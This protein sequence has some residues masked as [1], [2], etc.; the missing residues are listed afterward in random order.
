MS[1]RPLSLEQLLVLQVRAPLTESCER[2]I[3]E[4]LNVPENLTGNNHRLNLLTRIADRILQEH[5]SA[6][7]GLEERLF[8]LNKGKAEALAHDHS[9]RERQFAASWFY[10][11]AATA[12]EVL[13]N[14]TQDIS[15][16]ER[17]YEINRLS[18][19]I[20]QG[21]NPPDVRHAAHRY[22]FM[23]K[24]AQTIFERNNDATWAK[25]WYQAEMLSAQ[26]S[27]EKKHQA[28][29]YGKAG[30]AARQLFFITD[31]I[32]WTEKWYEAASAASELHAENFSQS[33]E[34]TSAGE[35]AKV[36]S[37]RTRDLLWA[38]RWYKAEVA[39]AQRSGEKHAARCSGLAG[40]AAASLFEATREL[41][42]AQKALEAYKQY[43]NYATKHPGFGIFNLVRRIESQVDRLERYARNAS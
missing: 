1:S 33:F 39:A 38:K 31:D 16:A 37:K 18:G 14:N 41:V 34:Y 30:K 23:G 32:N 7:A 20:A 8:H 2:W 27:S 12:A 9:A 5:P 10:S 4:L 6:L 17:W 21:L 22:G 26:L 40:D 11:R 36:L 19:E 29:S 3:A 15:W 13:Y 42:W 28:T 35:A 43:L 25:R 24:A